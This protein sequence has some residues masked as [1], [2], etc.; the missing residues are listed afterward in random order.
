MSIGR[1]CCSNGSFE[2]EYSVG[3]L[4][5]RTNQSIWFETL[6]EHQ[7]KLEVVNRLIYVKFKFYSVIIHDKGL[8]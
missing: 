4:Q 3:I 2:N 5:R 8:G 7:I 1:A 6:L